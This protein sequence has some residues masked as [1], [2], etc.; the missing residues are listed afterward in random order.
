MHE[1]ELKPWT[2]PETHVTIVH[3]SV[4]THTQVSNFTAS[5]L[6]SL[7]NI[8]DGFSSDDFDNTPAS[9]LAGSLDTVLNDKEFNTAQARKIVDKVRNFTQGRDYVI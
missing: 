4:C 5:T 9:A 2:Q 1:H 6:E 3:G 7:G 8:V